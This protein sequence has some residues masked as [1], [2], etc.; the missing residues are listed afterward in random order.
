MLS[1]IIRTHNGENVLLD[2]LRPLV[3]AAAEGAVRDVCFFD[4]GSTDGTQTIADAAGAMMISASADTSRRTRAALEA[5]HRAD[6]IMLLDQTTVLSP[7]WLAETISFVERQERV[8]SRKAMMSAVFRPEHEPEAGSADMRRRAAVLLA[9]RLLSTAK[10]SQGI[11]V[12]R[13][14][15]MGEAGSRFDWN[16]SDPGIRLAGLLRLR[17]RTHLAQP[18]EPLSEAPQGTGET[19][20]LSRAAL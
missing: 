17:S 2:V 13:S 1:V 16:A 19:N 3:S 6:W 15:L 12:R 8:K 5:A 18:I 9:N 7:S 11:L 20:A 10:L 14:D 4:T